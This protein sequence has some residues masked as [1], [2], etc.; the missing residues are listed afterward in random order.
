MM[1]TNVP[2]D[3]VN[4]VY[5]NEEYT[6]RNSYPLQKYQPLRFA[7]YLSLVLGAI[8]ILTSDLWY[9]HYAHGETLITQTVGPGDL[10]TKIS[11]NG[12]QH[13]ITGG[14]QLGTSLFHSFDQFSVATGEIAQFRTNQLTPDSSFNNILGRVTG[15]SPSAIFGAI[16]SAT[17]YPN[18]SLYL[19]NPYGIVFGPD[20]ILN[21]GGSVSFSTSN[22]VRLFD[23]TSSAN[24]Y[25][26]PTSDAVTAAGRTSILS[27]APLVDFGFVSPAAYGF[28][29]STPAAIAVQGSKLSNGQSIS[30]VGGSTGFKYINPD[31]ISLTS[32]QGGVT[33]NGGQLST[34]GGEINITSISSIG[35]VSLRDSM[36]TPGMTLNHIAFSEG[37]KLDVSG[38]A[39]GII[40]IRGGTLVVENTVL[41]ANTKNNHGAPVGIDIHITNNISVSTVDVPALTATTAGSG[42]AGAIHITSDTMN[43]TSKT[44]DSLT[45]AAIDTHTSGSGKAGRVMITTGNL[46]VSGDAASGGTSFI[47]SGTSGSNPGPGGDV[48]IKAHEIQM[49]D[50]A[51]TTG[52]FSA[53]FLDSGGAGTAGS[54]TIDANRL[55]MRFSS[56]ITDSNDFVHPVGTSGAITISAHDINFDHGSLSTSGYERSGP[57]TITSD[58]L[59]TYET[60]IQAITTAKAGGEI[61]ITSNVIELKDGSSI[62]STTNGNGDA[63]PIFLKATD[64]LG[65]LNSSHGGRPGGIFN[66]SSGENG[67]Q[68]NAGDITIETPLLQMTGGARINSSTATSGHGGN[69]TLKANSLFMSGEN[70]GFEIEPLFNLGATQSSGIFT[71]TIGGKCSSICGKAGDVDITTLSLMMGTGS[72]INSG[73][74][75]NGQGGNINISATNAITMSGKLSTGQT[76]GIQSRTIGKSPDAGMGGNISLVAGQSVTIQDGAT[77]SANSTGP[78]NAGNISVDAGRQLDIQDSSITTE[79]NVASGGNIDIKAVDLIRVANGSISSSV[80]GG[81]STAGGNITIDPKT[82][83]LQ[84]AQIR[85]NADQGNGGNIQITTPLFLK[86]STSII[87]ASSRFGLSG[88]VTIQS[89]TANLSGAV[90]QL[91][92][93]TSPPQVLLQN[94]CVAL[95]GGEQSTFILTGRNTLPV[96]PGGWLSSPVSMEH[97]TAVSPEHASTLMVQSPSRRSKTWPA[98]VTPKGEANVLSLRRLTPPGFLVRA[99]A[100]PSTGCPS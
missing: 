21:V 51:I 28:L 24:F 73:T 13:F 25:A 90:G 77:I 22:Y 97:W 54:V 18:A 42:N 83:V 61:R 99:F 68:G 43:V 26:D 44:V 1:T 37:A 29:N 16:D 65:I 20:A 85:A 64:H 11:S 80:Q 30:L 89:P 98:M 94:R 67:N 19:I 45:Y 33:I 91:V 17:Y 40:R 87:D 2:S 15:T 76:G 41:S 55:N 84:N 63:G 47:D 60:Q 39:G 49:Q 27:S 66:N 81:P 3:S 57:I 8:A 78:G 23:G 96:E 59:T 58:R 53:L 10:G 46:T 48:V 79:A 50:T 56:I 62:T 88:T 69:V 6:I 31:A 36:P 7:P 86:D 72:Q 70:E 93:K 9:T 100:T 95:A 52:N 75:S 34:R 71:R 82:V 92:S 14:K 74:S 4:N 38:N 5:M 32:V 12:N 35:E